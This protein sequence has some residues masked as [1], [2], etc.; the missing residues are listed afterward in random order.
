MGLPPGVCGWGLFAHEEF[1][2]LF[3]EIKEA[4]RS[5][6]PDSTPFQPEGRR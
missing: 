2:D 5:G 1:I 3:E 6:T 4:R